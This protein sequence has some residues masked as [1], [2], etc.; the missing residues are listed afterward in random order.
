M[1]LTNAWRTYAREHTTSHG[2]LWFHPGMAAQS[3]H[4]S[5]FMSRQDVNMEGMNWIAHLF[6]IT[7]GFLIDYEGSNNV[8][9]DYLA[10]MDGKSLDD[11]WTINQSHPLMTHE[12]YKIVETAFLATRDASMQAD[13]I[14]ESDEEIEKK[15]KA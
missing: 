7:Q 12:L 2:T 11:A 8:L 1:R 6:Y 4:V 13:D 15:E 5:D 14:P 3:Y 9:A 10:D